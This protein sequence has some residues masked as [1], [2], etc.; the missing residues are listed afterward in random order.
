MKISPAFI[1]KGASKK[2]DE[3]LARLSS[4]D[5]STNISE[6]YF[7]D[8]IWGG[9]TAAVN[10]YEVT[11]SGS[12]LMKFA[13]ISLFPVGS[14]DYIKYINEQGAAEK[15]EKLHKQG[16]IVIIGTS[17]NPNAQPSHHQYRWLFYIDTLGE[18][19][20][21][22][23]LDDNGNPKTKPLSLRDKYLETTTIRGGLYYLLWMVG[24]PSVEFV[25]I[26]ANQEVLRNFNDGT[27]YDMMVNGAFPIVA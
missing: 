16:D 27:Y 24:W 17:P 3:V 5:R 9:K 21:Y 23:E 15:A 22:P 20:A 14:V 11:N 1:W 4:F 6:F 25:A 13:D 2:T 8:P 19:M 7:C 18:V 26:N 12:W 10:L